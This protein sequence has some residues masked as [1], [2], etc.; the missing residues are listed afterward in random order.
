MRFLLL[1]MILVPIAA[2]AG[3]RFLGTWKSSSELS[4]EFNKAHANLAPHQID[5][6]NGV[7]GRSE[8]R[9]T[10]A[11]YIQCDPDRDFM[12]NDRVVHWKGTKFAVPYEVA[13]E[14]DSTAILTFKWPDGVVRPEVLHFVDDDT[15]WIY[16]GDAPE[17][18]DL[19]AREYFKRVEDRACI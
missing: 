5:F 17:V 9:I 4:M 11:A 8:A 1:A 14:S 18:L 10:E 2:L 16:L 12:L 3:P 7:L 19:H 15:F 6:L 13:F